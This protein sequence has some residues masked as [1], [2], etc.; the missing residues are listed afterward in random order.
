MKINTNE[1]SDLN[2]IELIKTS[3]DG[4]WKIIVIIIISLL[5]T[6][7]YIN[8]SI[9]KNFYNAITEIKPI[10]KIEEKKYFVLNSTYFLNPSFMTEGLKFKKEENINKFED[11]IEIEKDSTPNLIDISSEL[12]LDMMLE[13]LYDRA[14]LEEAIHKFKLIDV[15]EYSNKLLYDDAVVQ[16][17]ST[18]KITTPLELSERIKLKIGLTKETISYP[19]IEFSYN[20]VNKWKKALDYINAK[21]NKTIREDLE[22]LYTDFLESLDI[23]KNYQIDNLTTRINNLSLDYERITSDRILYLDEQSKIAKKLG[24]SKSTVGAQNFGDQS[25]YITS[26]VTDTPFYLRGYEAIDKE[27]ELIQ[28]RKNKNAFVEGLFDLEKARRNLIQDKSIERIRVN[29]YK[30]PLLDEENFY[31]A[32]INVLSTRFTYLSYNKYL[33]F[34]VAFGLVVGVIYVLL[35]NI[36]Q[37]KKVV[38]KKTN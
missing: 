2:I 9:D 33:V 13:L 24:I 12:L 3:W 26:I 34:A 16:L 18:V 38:R 21:A 27:I 10:R 32:K 30:S 7:L 17:A 11:E 35:S 4:K 23:E 14:L 6:Y 36:F 20:D 37:N 8:N 5:S 25:G 31:A 1:N 15:N 19:T 28:S 29:L 22:N